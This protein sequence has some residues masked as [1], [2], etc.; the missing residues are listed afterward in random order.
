MKKKLLM[1]K[2]G[3]TFYWASFF[4]NPSK[5]QVIY[6]IYSFCRMIDDT[7]DEA[8]NATIAKQ[9]LS[10]LI[11]AWSKKKSHPVINILNDIPKDSWPNNKLMKYFFKGQVSDIKFST[12]KTERAL[13]IYCYQVAGTVGLMICDV[14]GIKDKNMRFF[15]IDLGIAMQLVNISR[16]IRE[17]GFRNRIYIPKKMMKNITIDDLLN[18]DEKIASDVNQARIKIIALA[19]T[20]FDSAKSA[21]ENLPK[22]ASLGVKLASTLYQEIG[23]KVMR[24]NYSLKEKRSYVTSIS[25]AFITIMVIISHFLCKKQKLAAHDPMLH[26][27]IKKFPDAHY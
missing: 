5:I 20:Y 1:R 4:L 21:V 19:N 26:T 2:H 13:I 6:S 23:Y 9:K 8:R 3:K 11:S 16:D 7:V 25:K 12:M 24:S 22:G 27:Y 10:L 15:A 17:D 18:P 14:F